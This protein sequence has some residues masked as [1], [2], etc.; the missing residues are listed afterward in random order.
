M[1]KT[2]IALIVLTSLS[3][4]VIQTKTNNTNNNT[5]QIALTAI[6]WSEAYKNSKYNNFGCDDKIIPIE[7]NRT[8]NIQNILKQMFVYKDYDAKKWYYNVFDQSKNIEIEKIYIDKNKNAIINI[9][10]QVHPAWTCDTPRFTAQ[11][12]NTIK[13]NNYAENVKIYINWE[14]I[15]YYLSEKDEQDLYNDM[16]RDTN[17][18]DN[19]EKNINQIKSHI[20]N[21]IKYYETFKEEII[22]E[23][24]EWW[25]KIYYE[26]SSVYPAIYRKIITEYYWET[27]KSIYKL[28]FDIYWSLIYIS[29]NEY[30]YNMPIYSDGFDN[31]QTIIQKN[32]YYFYNNKLIKRKFND[33]YENKEIDSKSNEFKEK[34]WYLIKL[35]QE[36]SK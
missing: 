14:D 6:N 15:N 36:L 25:N 4:C 22:W 13:L 7:I 18:K 24:S 23:S 29:E 10:W 12:L 30:D 33:E 21:N 2:I 11:I 8:D 27:W 9:S 19:L 28:Y 35:S 26:D 16:I 1:K 3:W 5:T 20:D 31:K 17:N 32:K 34:E